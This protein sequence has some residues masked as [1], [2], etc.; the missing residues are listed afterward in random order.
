MR[1]LSNLLLA[2]A[3]LGAV[4]ASA[5]VVVLHVGFAPVL[6]PSMEPDFAPGALL[7]TRAV[8]AA[9]VAVGD[10]VVLPR[11]DAAGERYAH[12]VISKDTSTGSVVVRTKG[13][14]N[15]A[16]DP[17]ALRIVSDTVPVAVGD[18]PF[19]GRAALLG[20]YA[21]VKVALIVLIGLAVLVAAKRALLRPAR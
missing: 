6:S 11:P 18:V 21:G 8:P 20:Q 5:L 1:V 17:Q 19:A 10:V 3:A 4:V 9:D 14:A 13:D 12:R 16:A 15:E 7:V 2:A